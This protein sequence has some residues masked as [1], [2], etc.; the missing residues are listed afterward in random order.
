MFSK[1]QISKYVQGSIDVIAANALVLWQFT[2][3]YIED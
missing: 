2:L 1:P 3:N